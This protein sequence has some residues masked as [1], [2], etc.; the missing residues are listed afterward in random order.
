MRPLRLFIEDLDHLRQS[1]ETILPFSYLT[2][3]L[4]YGGPAIEA[5]VI[6]AQKLALQGSHKTAPNMLVSAQAFA[7]KWAKH[8]ATPLTPHLF[9]L[10]SGSYLERTTG[11]FGHVAYL[12]DM[13]KGL[14]PEAS[15]LMLAQ[16]A[17]PADFHPDDHYTLLANAA[18]MQ[19]L[20]ELD[21]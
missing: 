16:H 8:N 20:A 10:T 4:P 1:P 18:R 19:L 21:F 15:R 17:Q 14:L 7:E 5:K 11:D 6:V 9:A 12:S 2:W 3:S 13:A